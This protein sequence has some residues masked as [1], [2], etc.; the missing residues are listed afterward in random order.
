LWLFEHSDSR[1]VGIDSDRNRR[2][3]IA[4]SLRDTD[5]DGHTRCMRLHLVAQRR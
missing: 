1:R 5:R 3:S 2:S 4:N